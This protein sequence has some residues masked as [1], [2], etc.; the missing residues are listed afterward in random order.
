MVLVHIF[1][2]IARF[3][4]RW[5]SVEEEI[6]LRK[7]RDEELCQL[8]TLPY[9]ERLTEFVRGSTRH[10]VG[11]N[12]TI[13]DFRPLYAM[14]IHHLQ[15]RLAKEIS[16]LLNSTTCD[17]QL[18]RLRITLRQYSRLAKNPE[19]TRQART[20]ICQKNNIASALRDFEF[21]HASR[22]E[23]AFVKDIAASRIDNGPGSKLLGSIL[24]EFSLQLKAGSRY[25][26]YSDTDLLGSFDPFLAESGKIGPST[27]GTTREKAERVRKRAK[28]FHMALKRFLFAILGGLAIVVPV[29]IIALGAVP[30]KTIVTVAIA[31]FVFALTVAWASTASP[32]NLLGATAAYAA[33]LMVFVPQ[34]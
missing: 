9:H 13:L 3:L 12:I 29:L 18:E 4:N 23:T 8:E 6:D 16:H 26:G 32:E 31:I 21:I 33:V 24:S 34:S 2:S 11:N 22:W 14:N 15:R 25:R 20:N 30:T 1:T 27:R 28:D 7:A 10:C 19:N 17:I 5:G